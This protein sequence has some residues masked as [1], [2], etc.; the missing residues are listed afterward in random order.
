MS[1]PSQ[2]WLHFKKVGM[3]EKVRCS[4]CLVELTFC[5]STSS[6]TYHLQKVH[7]VELISTKRKRS[8][9]KRVIREE[10]E[11]SSNVLDVDAN[12][13]GPSTRYDEIPTS[14]SE[15]KKIK[16]RNSIRNL[17]ASFEKISSFSC[18]GQ[19]YADATD[20]LL[21]MIAADN[22]PLSMTKRK[23]FKE[24]VRTLQPHYNL[25]SAETV[26]VMMENK[27]E[28]LK[29][30]MKNILSTK[31]N[32]I[33]T[34]DLWTESM[35]TRAYL[36]ITAHYLDDWGL[37]IANVK[38]IVTDNK[39]N[40]VGACKQAVS[41]QKHISCLAHNLNLAVTDALGL[42]KTNNQID[43]EEVP[44]PLP[45]FED[46]EDE[47]DQIILGVDVED[48][49]L[50]DDLPSFKRVVSKIK[51]IVNFFRKSERASEELKLLRMTEWRKAE[52]ECLRLIQEVRIRWNSVYAMLD[53]F[54]LLCELVQRVLAKITR[55]KTSKEKPPPMITAGEE[56]LVR[57]VRDLLKPAWQVTKEIC[58][59]KSTL[60]E[61]NAVHLVAF[62]IKHSLLAEIGKQLCFME[63]LPMPAKATILGLRFKKLHFTDSRNFARALSSIDRELK[64]K[65]LKS[66]DEER[67]RNM[68]QHQRGDSQVNDIW[69]HHDALRSQQL[70]EA[71]TDTAGGLSVE[72]RQY[73]NRPTI[74]PYVNQFEEWNNIKHAYPNLYKIALEYLP[75]LANSV[76]SERLFSKAGQIITMLRNRL[77][78]KHLNQLIFL[79]S[80]DFEM[81][82]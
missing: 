61:Y 47:E 35:T 66:G 49:G 70:P 14:S 26:T 43:Q 69:V 28:V 62:N 63:K 22:Q 39:P 77:S 4:H 64:A 41:A 40:V 76:P 78:G 27:Y 37:D 25:S 8:T 74:P 38:A 17:S 59:E 58:A 32:I 2:V 82:K 10:K 45:V 52:K 75:I 44:L 12:E 24:F 33:L 79:V 18:G 42:Y 7:Q 73:L 71:D 19:R 57:E 68:P 30:K 6:M 3:G 34:T 60:R 51:K 72:L 53:R 54:L 80:L 23:G 46:S 21:Y 31:T 13:A 16:T 50:D 11:T 29:T 15:V 20:A 9:Y 55:E 56:E 48:R 67:A 1:P 81:W 36:G 5:N 65:I